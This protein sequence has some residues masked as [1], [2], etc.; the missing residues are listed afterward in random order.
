MPNLI[1][2]YIGAMADRRR[3]LPAN[4]RHPPRLV[5]GELLVDG[6]AGAVIVIVLSIVLERRDAAHCPLCWVDKCRG[7]ARV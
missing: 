1:I 6:P 5:A 7:K 3:R 4:R 2:V